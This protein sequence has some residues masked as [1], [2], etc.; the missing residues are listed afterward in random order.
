MHLAPHNP[1]DRRGGVVAGRD[2]AAGGLDG[3]DGG[4]GRARDDNVHGLPERGRG[5]DAVGEQ[6]DALARLVDAARVGE[7][8]DGDRARWVDAALVDPGLDAVEVYGGEVDGEAGSSVNQSI[9]SC[10]TQKTYADAEKKKKKKKDLG[11]DVHILKP[12][13][14]MHDMV[15][16]LPAVEARWSLV[17]LFLAAVATAGGLALAGGGA[18]ASADP[19]VVGARVVGEGGEDVGVAALVLQLQLRE[20]G[21]QG[22]GQLSWFGKELGQPRRQR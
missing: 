19:L 15:R 3:G 13:F 5:A 17:V 6:L 4:V 14:P 12:P 10:R 21:R 16:R 18:A 22:E 2:R 8:A 1:R 7:L 9:M 11:R 20:Q